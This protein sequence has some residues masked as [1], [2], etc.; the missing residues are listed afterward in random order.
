M[1]AAGGAAAPA[2]HVDDDALKARLVAAGVPAELP[3]S[4][5]STWL[6][7][8]EA[9]PPTFVKHKHVVR[10]KTVTSFFLDAK[11]TDLETYAFFVEPVYERGTFS[12]ICLCPGCTKKEPTKLIDESG[13][14]SR[15]TTC[16][17]PQMSSPT[18]SRSASL[19]PAAPT[20]TLPTSTRCSLR[21]RRASRR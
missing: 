18:T 19:S 7:L 12:V 14:H 1:A 5:N 17:L 15:I 8:K 11:V 6:L 4:F 9:T 10:G 20:S 2:T 3:V 21:R 16:R 13:S